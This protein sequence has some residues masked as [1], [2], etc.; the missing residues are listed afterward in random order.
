MRKGILLAVCAGALMVGVAA[1]S[2]ASACKTTKCF[3]KAIRTLRAQVNSLNAQ[4][5]TQNATIA[6][7]RRASVTSYFGYDYQGTPSA[8]SA[9]DFTDPGDPVDAWML[10]VQPGEC[11]TPAT[12]SSASPTAVRRAAS[13]FAPLTLDLGGISRSP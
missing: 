13:P 7:I 9:L 4:V 2:T 8:T 5:Q 1:P 12:A 3:N 6:C 10:A 11:G